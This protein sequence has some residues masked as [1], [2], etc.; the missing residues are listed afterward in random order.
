MTAYLTESIRNVA[1]LGH[2]GS[3]K[4]SLAEA[5]LR[6]AGAIH[7]TGLTEKGSTVSDFT[8]EEKQHHHSIHNAL[9]HADYA[10]CHINLIDTPGS[11]DFIGQPLSALTAVETA[12]IVI[13]AIAGVEQMTRRLMREAA[14]RKLCRMIIVN[15]IDAP[16]VN[17]PE[18]MQQIRE[19]F[20]KECLPI[21]LPAADRASVIDCFFTPPG[22][23]RSPKT[24][25]DSV[26]HAHTA[27]VEQCVEVDEKLMS[28]YLEQGQ[29]IKP[30][31]LHEPFEA[32][33][34][35]GHLIPVCFVS[36]RTHDN[37]EKSVGVS[38]LLDVLA[39]LAPSPL[40]GNPRPFIQ[41]SDTDNELH[42]VAD[43]AAHVLAHVFSVRIDPFVGKL[44]FFRIHQGTLTNQAHLFIDDPKLGEL[45]KPFRVNHLYRVQGKDH[46]EIQSAVAGDIAAMAKVDELHRDA[47]LHDSHEQDNIHYKPEP[48]PIPVF[49]TAIVTEARGDETKLADALVKLLEEDPTLRVVNDASTKQLVLYGMGELHLRV[50][51]EKLRARYHVSVG[52]QPVK[53]SYRETV[54]AKADGHHRHKKQ[55]GGAGQFGEVYLRVEPLERGGGIEFVNEVVGGAIPG[56]YISAVEKG[57]RLAVDSGAVAGYPLQD[58]R[59]T[60]Y[61]GKHH[62]V[63]S[64]EIAFVTAGKRAFIDAVFKARPAV[65]EPIAKLTITVPSRFL[66][67]IAG[68]LS[69]KRGKIVNTDTLPG[70]VIVIHASVPLSEI[71][72]YQSQLKSVTSGQGSYTMEI[73]HYEPVPPMVQQQIIAQHRPHPEDD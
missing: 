30:E 67:D 2:G 46:V 13:D 16:G 47:V 57:V 34:R 1:L 50:T 54:Q 42:P 59:V 66:G 22:P 26:A 35:Q 52:T 71:T 64:K 38:E 33:L 45:K 21:N 8:P 68:D 10:G 4:T 12:A 28:L 14:D 5:L 39:K 58:V 43:P 32:A 72:T 62:A 3:G 18:L 69:A 7:H 25:F 40:E 61:D 53:V 24:D 73:S 11:P 70:G 49:G 63:D 41:G 20:G 51:I 31:Q 6:T 37:H 19:S 36:A 15:K 23:D 17:L 29:E 48:F 56:Q 27:L 9:L 65:L 55:T 60:V 44:C